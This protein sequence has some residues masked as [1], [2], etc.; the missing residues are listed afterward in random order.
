M[1]T[2]SPGRT[3]IDNLCWHDLTSVTKIR[4]VLTFIVAPVV[5]GLY[6]HFTGT[7]LIPG[8]WAGVDLVIATFVVAFAVRPRKQAA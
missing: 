8:A 7:S 5:A 1:L 2:G 4:I 3:S 6:G